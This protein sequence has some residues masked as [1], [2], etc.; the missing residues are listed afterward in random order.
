MDKG[1]LPE[2]CFHV[3]FTLLAAYLLLALIL[4][5]LKPLQDFISSTLTVLFTTSG[6][7]V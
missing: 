4:R 6:T 7:Y 3:V 1:K 2:Y 5:V